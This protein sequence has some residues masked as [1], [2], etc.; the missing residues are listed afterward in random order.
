MPS[1][2]EEDLSLITDVRYLRS[3]RSAR[4]GNVT[5]AGNYLDTLT[6]TPL[7]DLDIDD[8]ERRLETV[9]ENID[10]FESI[11]D[12]I[13]ELEDED[14]LEAEQVMLDDQRTGNDT[15]RCNF[16]RRIKAFYLQRKGS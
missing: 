14:S 15:V 8:L 10:I 11:Q 1:R 12:R 2:G 16:S 6:H 3:K 13:E 7:K 9:Q 4:K 5:R